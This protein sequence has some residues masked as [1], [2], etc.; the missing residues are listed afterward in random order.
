MGGMPPVDWDEHKELLTGVNNTFPDLR[1]NIVDMV[2]EGD[3]VVIRLNVT[4]THTRG[5]RYTTYG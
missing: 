3:K 5:P 4:D 2:A 1:H